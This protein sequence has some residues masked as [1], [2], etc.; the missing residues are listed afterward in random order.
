MIRIII[1]LSAMLLVTN[2]IVQA[3]D[4]EPFLLKLGYKDGYIKRADRNASMREYEETYSRNRKTLSYNLE[5][6]SKN[7]LGL[8][9]M[10]EQGVIL[11]GVALDTA[12]NGARLNL[13]KSKTLGLGLKDMSNSDRTIYLGINLGW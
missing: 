10:P 1:V 12:I 9:G 6:Y 3:E 5:S 11:M 2:S 13:N 4:R 8:I 7:A